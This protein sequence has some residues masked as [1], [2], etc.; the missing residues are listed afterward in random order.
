MSTNTSSER[1][2][3]RMTLGW[4]FNASSLP[5]G[6]LSCN[7]RVFIKAELP[8]FLCCLIVANRMI[9]DLKYSRAFRVRRSQMLLLVCKFT[10]TNKNGN[11]I[12]ETNT[13]GYTVVWAIYTSHTDKFT[14][15]H[16]VFEYLAACLSVILATSWFVPFA[17]LWHAWW[18]WEKNIYINMNY[19]YPTTMY[20]S[21]F[22]Q[23]YIFLVEKYVHNF[24]SKI[25]SW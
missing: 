20:A 23:I 22:A 8:K 3:L 24:C 13:S 1:R 11:F 17:S 6:T 2:W 9:V 5:F 16:M 14:F 18:I 19:S 10:C 21:I 7:Y 4:L 15:Q 12:K 25:F